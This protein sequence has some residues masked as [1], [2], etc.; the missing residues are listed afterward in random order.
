MSRSSLSLQLM[1]V[2]ATAGLVFATPASAQVDAAAAEILWKQNGCGKCHH[3]TQS[4]KGPSLRKIARDYRGKPDAEREIIKH[5]VTPKKVKLDDG[6]EEDHKT[7]DT[8]DARA[9]SNMARWILNR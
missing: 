8:R 7:V 9:L 2:V 4:R 6:T 3:A 5:L 1:A